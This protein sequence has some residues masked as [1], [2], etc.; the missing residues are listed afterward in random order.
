MARGFAVAFYHSGEW[1][2]ARA[3]AMRRDHGLCQ[4]CLSL[5]REVPAEIVHHVV[6]LTPANLSDPRVA[7]DPGNLVSLCRD[8]HAVVHGFASPP[9]RPGL[10]FDEDGNLVQADTPAVCADGRHSESE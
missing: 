5:G 4:R 7:T 9:C 3:E 1:K 8:C 10:A 6:E 2:R